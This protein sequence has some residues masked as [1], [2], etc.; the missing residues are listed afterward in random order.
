MK[1]L[2]L[3]AGIVFFMYS[4]NSNTDK[5]ASTTSDTTKM[6]DTKMAAST[7]N[8]D[9][10]YTLDH[11]YNEWQTGD[12]H[13]AA[14][15]MKALK[16]Y[17]TNNIPEC[18]SYFGDSVNLRFDGFQAKMPHDSI[19]GFLTM[20]RGQYT[21]LTVHLDDWESVI[22]KDKKEEWV[23]LWYKE[24]YTDKKGKVDSIS[25]VND[26]K[27]K[28]GKIVVLDESVMHYMKK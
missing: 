4:C 2:I 18:V 1:R 8:I 16:A 24:I 6:A 5:S 10:A 13:H 28:N 20:G 22:S 27:M 26:A 7:D 14:N 19:A 23:T 12:P 9:Y 25:V 3:L 21:N 17:E 15:V 11:P